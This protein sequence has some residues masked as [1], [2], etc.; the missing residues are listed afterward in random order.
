MKNFYL[1]Y[2]V[3]L[4]LCKSKSM[5]CI[6]LWSTQFDMFCSSKNQ[7]LSNCRAPARL[8]HCFLQ[9]FYKRNFK[10]I[11]ICVYRGRYWSTNDLYK[12]TKRSSHQFSR[13]DHNIQ[14]SSQYNKWSLIY[15]LVHIYTNLISWPVVNHWH[16]FPTIFGTEVHAPRTSEQSTVLLANKTNC[17]SIHYGC[18]F[19]NIFH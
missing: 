19:L 5:C 3:Y 13:K 1:T 8:L 4:I 6:V 11:C 15:R 12:V 17:R 7:L 18:I 16:H 10:T 9:P 14:M 2:N